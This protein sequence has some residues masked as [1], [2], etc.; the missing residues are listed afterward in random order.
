LIAVERRRLAELRHKGEISLSS[1]R[2]IQHDL[3]LEE[4]RLAG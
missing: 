2:R 1:E 4:S 3:D